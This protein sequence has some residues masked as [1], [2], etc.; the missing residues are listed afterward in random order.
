[1]QK[2]IHH[3][4]QF[5]K[6]AISLIK[7]LCLIIIALTSRL[8]TYITSSANLELKTIDYL[9][10]Y[11]DKPLI[12]GREGP[13]DYFLWQFS[14]GHKIK[15]YIQD[16]NFS[17]ENKVILDL[18]CGRGGKTAYYKSEGAKM[19]I[20]L[21]LRMEALKIANEFTAKHSP[22]E[23]AFFLRANAFSLPFH[24]DSFDH[25]ILNDMVEHILEY[26]VEQILN[27]M[28]RVLNPS[29]SIII[30]FPP[31][32]NPRGS[33]LYDYVY[34][35]YCHLLF[36]QKA[37]IEYCKDEANPFVIRQFEELNRITAYRFRKIV[38]RIGLKP[39]TYNLLKNKHLFANIP[40][41]ENLFIYRVFCVL[42]K[43]NLK[44]QDLVFISVDPWQEE[45]WA[46]KQMFASLLS[47]YCRNVIYYVQPARSETH[48]PNIKRK[49]KNLYLVDIPFMPKFLQHTRYSRLGVQISCLAL[50]A[51]LKVLRVRN[52]IFIIYQPQNMAFAKK[53]STMFGKN[54]L[55]YDLTDDWSE[56]PGISE[57]R[58]NQIKKAEEAVLKEVDK[59]FAVSDKLFEKAQY[60]N[61][62]TYYLPNATSFENFNKVTQPIHISPEIR[63]HP[64]PRIGYVGKITPWRIDFDLIRYLAEEKPKWSIIM[65]GPIHHEAKMIVDKLN[66]LENIFFLG[67]KNYYSLPEYIKGFNAC[68]LPHKIDNLT[69]S[70]DPIKLY[71]YMATGKP[72]VST[73]IKEALKF[74]DV[75]IVAK[76]KKNF[77][78]SLNEIISKSTNELCNDKQ[79]NFAQNNSWQKRTEQ[80]I[81]ILED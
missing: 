35:P 70:M 68:I 67:P 52:P 51:V 78:L 42:T 58:K 37:L 11:F 48:Y 55:C 29:G 14:Q 73:A 15:D 16:S 7:I 33:H 21:D 12:G 17:F 57:T 39:T 49:K 36:S 76:S 22:G 5:T 56:F 44:D 79:I 25:I 27:E 28:K 10:S 6:F 20:G 50:W 77:V 54:L 64:E 59:V 3:F 23:N 40:V 47:D 71:D 72:I 1:M 45:R 30:D 62:N 63:T 4:F 61:T 34:I 81:E 9:N 41:L 46:R 8:I 43:N 53:L 24:D 13:E 31:Y 75:I 80:L 19:V 66:K 26:E 32:Y 2:F 69:D 38:K 65:I 60:I 18:G 74:K